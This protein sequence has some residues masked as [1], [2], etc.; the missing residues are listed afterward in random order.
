MVRLGNSDQL[1]S[2][3]LGYKI[4]NVLDCHLT[5]SYEL[6]IYSLARSIVLLAYFI[7]SSGH[8]ALRTGCPLERH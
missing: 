5:T 4:I 8:P 1:N 2:D 3:K 6:L 7:N